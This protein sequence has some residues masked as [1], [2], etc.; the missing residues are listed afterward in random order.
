MNDLVKD[1][2]NSL[3]DCV[4]GKYKYEEYIKII[5][6]AGNYCFLNQFE[7][8]IDG[9]ENIISNLKAN[10]LIE[11]KPLNKR[12]N[13]LYL[14]DTAIKYLE[15]KNSKE[16]FSDINKN[17]SQKELFSSA[18]KFHLIVKNVDSVDDKSTINELKDRIENNI[19]SSYEESKKI[20]KNI[21]EFFNIL[22]RFEGETL[23]LTILDTGIYEAYDYLKQINLVKA[24]NLG[25]ENINII[26]YS[27]SDERGSN[28]FRQFERARN[29]K[30][31][32]LSIMNS[33]EYSYNYRFKEDN[34]D[35]PKDKVQSYIPEFKVE[36]K[37]DLYY[38]GEY[39]SIVP[40]HDNEISSQDRKAI[41][42]LINRLNVSKGKD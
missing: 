40:D 20:F 18:Y 37:E 15:L 2:S 10:K 21:Y 24:L 36:S 4:D 14:T 39:I 1:T 33:Y 6:K 23:E 3:A 16:G 29:N 17:P 32:A 41:Y 35:I 25:I 38:I 42:N 28:L 31:E 7:N 9:G 13:Y 5:H 34:I 22:P 26:I 27:Y 19:N 30:D 11:I 8:L 12:Y